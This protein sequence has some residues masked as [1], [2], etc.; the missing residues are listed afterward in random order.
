MSTALERFCLM[1]SVAIPIAEV[2][3]HM[4]VVEGCGYPMSESVVRRDAACCPVAKRAAYS[5]SP[6]LATTQG[7]M[8]EKTCMAPLMRVGSL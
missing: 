2:L 6:A 5:A 8:E 4:I 7:I 1:L 3:S